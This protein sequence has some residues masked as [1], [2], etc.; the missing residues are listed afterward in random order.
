MSAIGTKRTNRNV[1]HL[2][3]F[4]AKRTLTEPRAYRK[5]IYTYTS[6][7]SRIGI[8]LRVDGTQTVQLSASSRELPAQFGHL[9]LQ[10]ALGGH[11]F[12]TALA[13]G[14]PVTQEKWQE[15]LRPHRRDAFG[16]SQSLRPWRSPVAAL[17]R[18]N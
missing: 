12:G 16:A 8:A 3:A 13:D 11:Q 18:L 7:G 15:H 4:E 5:P 14:E 6:S 9:I 10:P 2:S 1:C 17:A